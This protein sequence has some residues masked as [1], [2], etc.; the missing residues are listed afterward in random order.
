MV[1]TLWNIS[2]RRE[3]EGWQ[4][5]M[6]ALWSSRQQRSKGTCTSQIYTKI[7]LLPNT[8][9]PTRV[10]NQYSKQ[11]LPFQHKI[12]SLC[13]NSKHEHGY[14][15]TSPM[16]RKILRT[17]SSQN[18]VTNPVTRTMTDQNVTPK[19]STR[20][21]DLVSASLASGSPARTQITVN[22]GP[23]GGEMLEP[24][25]IQRQALS[26]RVAEHHYQDV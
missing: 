11:I 17:S 16:P 3:Q 12:I 24:R 23:V 13:K 6:W 1:F 7:Q 15:H 4:I 14:A 26:K 5:F 8:H 21:R 9:T 19:S 20:G 10:T 18:S 22:A 25:A 2:S